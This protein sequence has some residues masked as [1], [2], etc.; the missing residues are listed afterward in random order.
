MLELR[1]PNIGHHAHWIAC[2]FHLCA[3][4]NPIADV[5]PS[6]NLFLSHTH[7]LNVPASSPVFAEGDPLEQGRHVV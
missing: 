4:G 7:Q 3:R 1:A 6:S 2:V 5:E